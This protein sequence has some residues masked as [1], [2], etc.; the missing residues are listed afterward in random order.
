MAKK[1]ETTKGNYEMTPEE[2]QAGKRPPIPQSTIKILWAKSAGRCEFEGCGE[3]LYLDS[4]T[5]MKGNFANVAHIVS[6]TQTG[7]R[8]RNNYEGDQTSEEANLM[9]MCNKHHH[10]IDVEKVGEYSE[11]RLKQMKKAFEEDTQMKIGIPS[12]RKTIVVTYTAKIGENLPVIGEDDVTDALWTN[13]RYPDQS[14]FIEIGGNDTY[15]LDK[16]EKYWENEDENLIRTFKDRVK[17]YKSR[18]GTTHYSIFAIAPMPLLV[19]LGTLINDI[20]SADIYQ[21]HREPQASWKWG[22][23]NNLDFHL[24]APE[25]KDGE[26]VLVF[27]ISAS[28]IINRIEAKNA[29]KSQ[30]IWIITVDNPNNDIITSQNQLSSFRSIVRQSLDTIRKASSKQHLHVYMAMPVSCAI[31]FG[32]CWMPKADMDLWLHDFN[33]ANGEDSLAIKIENK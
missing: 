25:K 18:Y 19:R 22:N 5:N 28:A 17:G 12:N 24:K 6:W 11:E 14:T 7:P 32:R 20:S 15:I 27:A 29:D 26:P 31:E 16:E 2:K 10:L 30:S 23:S 13:Y 1:K 8:G 9:L 4:L 3:C 33:T 21:K